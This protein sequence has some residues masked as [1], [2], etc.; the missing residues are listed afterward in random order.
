MRNVFVLIAVFVCMMIQVPILTLL[1]LTTFSVDAPLVA[2]LYIASTGPGVVGM[3]I[4][5]LMGLL[6]DLFMPGG[7]P[8][9]Q[10]EILVVLFLLARMVVSRLQ[11]N[12]TLPLIIVVFLSSLVSLGLFMLLSVIFDRGYQHSSTVV[13]GGLAQALLTALLSPLL[14]KLFGVA[15]GR[16]HHRRDTRSLF[17]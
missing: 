13:T 12:R 5:S 7:L 17:V 1:G 11:L 15:D 16:F 9:M 4:V 14:F 6:T 2:M 3:V 8:G 10:M